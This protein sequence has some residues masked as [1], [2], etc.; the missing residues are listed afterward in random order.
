[1][2]ELTVAMMDLLSVLGL[3]LLFSLKWTGLAALDIKQLPG[4]QECVII[5]NISLNKLLGGGN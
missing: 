3:G 2:S 5:N 1:M 4:E